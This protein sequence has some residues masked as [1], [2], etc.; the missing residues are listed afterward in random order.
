[1]FKLKR[2][3]VAM[4]DEIASKHEM[5]KRLNTY[6]CFY[7]F[8]ILFYFIFTLVFIILY[9]EVLLV[10]GSILFLINVILILLFL[11]M[12]LRYIKIMELD[13]TF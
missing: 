13:K 10:L 8:T 7:L 11:K 1:M 12:G 5:L 3:E 4:D 2:V 6:T 9:K